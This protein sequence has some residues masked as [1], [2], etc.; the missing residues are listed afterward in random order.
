MNHGRLHKLGDTKKEI[1]Y[2]GKVKKTSNGQGIILLKNNLLGKRAYIIF[3]IHRKNIEDHVV[4][5][6]DKIEN[7][8]I[9]PNNDH[10]CRILLAKEY[11]GRKCVI[12][13]QEG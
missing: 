6:V 11:V 5:A 3:P 10:T 13:L 9:H 2:D 7:K 1:I 12:I 4:L 8:G